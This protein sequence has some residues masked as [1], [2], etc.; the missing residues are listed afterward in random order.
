MLPLTEAIGLG[1]LP[2]AADLGRLTASGRCL[3]QRPSA[4]LV[5]GEEK[6]GRACQ[7]CDRNRKILLQNVQILQHV[8]KIIQE[9][10]PAVQPKG[11]V[12]LEQKQNRI[13]AL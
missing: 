3:R 8:I 4:G 6:T 12:H 10:P 9:L 2:S 11:K 5:E 13:C 7:R 1:P